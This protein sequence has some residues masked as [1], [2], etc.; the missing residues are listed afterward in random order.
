MYI[1]SQYIHS[2]NHVLLTAN[3]IKISP[4]SEMRPKLVYCKRSVMF[5]INKILSNFAVEDTTEPCNCP[6][7]R[8]WA[9]MSSIASGHKQNSQNSWRSRT[10]EQSSLRGRF[11][12]SHPS[13]LRDSVV[14]VRL[15][16]P[17]LCIDKTCSWA[18]CW[19]QNHGINMDATLPVKPNNHSMY[20]IC[21]ASAS[22]CK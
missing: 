16:L 11:L 6:N 8:V 12:H 1:W 10:P 21:F 18:M 19:R 4:A 2:L 14:P 3:F 22:T 9:E 15:A 20:H 13:P 5:Y 7:T 17:R